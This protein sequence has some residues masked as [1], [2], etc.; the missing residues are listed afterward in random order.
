[1][2]CTLS[3]LHSYSHSYSRSYS[4]SY[5]HSHRP[6]GGRFIAPAGTTEFAKRWEP[7]PGDIVSYKH[8]GFMFGSNKPKVPTLYRIRDDLQWED[9]VNN[10][11]ENIITPQ[12]SFI[13]IYFV[14]F[15][16]FFY[17]FLVG[18]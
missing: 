2:K 12:G 9:V 13:F 6:N 5:S 18:C 10:F 4:H 8:R 15:Y 1:V 17:L 11:K 3:H 7:K 16:L 14:Y